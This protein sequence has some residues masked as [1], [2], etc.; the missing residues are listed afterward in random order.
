MGDVYGVNATAVRNTPPTRVT[1]AER[2]GNVKLI[3]DS[4]EAAALASGEE[5]VMGMLKAGD[6]LLPISIIQHDDLGAGSDATLALVLE[7]VVSGTETS[8]ISGIDAD[9]A[10]LTTIG[11]AIA[12]IDAFPRRVATDHWIKLKFAGTTAATGTIR[13]YM[14]VTTGAN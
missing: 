1:N 2:G 7:D 9:A 8:I 12:N 11:S 3:Y 10:A 6:T 4:Y 13:T 5:I 14:F